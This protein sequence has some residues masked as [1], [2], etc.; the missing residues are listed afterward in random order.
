MEDPD[1]DG[2]LVARVEKHSSPTLRDACRRQLIP[3]NG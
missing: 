2:R 1:A 3:S